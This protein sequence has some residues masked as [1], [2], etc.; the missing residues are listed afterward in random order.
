MVAGCGQ[1]R[2]GRVQLQCLTGLFAI[3]IATSRAAWERATRLGGRRDR[4]CKEQ[5]RKV[6]RAMQ[7]RRVA[8]PH[9]WYS[10]TNKVS[11][12]LPSS[13]SVDTWRI[14]LYIGG[15]GVTPLS[16]S[17]QVGECTRVDD[18]W[19]L[20]SRCVYGVGTGSTT[21][22]DP[23]CSIRT[24]EQFVDDLEWGGCFELVQGVGIE[25]RCSC[26]G[27]SASCSGSEGRGGAYV[28]RINMLNVGT[29]RNS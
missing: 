9:Y 11:Q 21:F 27:G 8:F 2:T 5:V 18:G 4:L 19:L 20:V 12:Y 14:S 3:S 24:D 22:L 6:Q 13:S 23:G 25:L 26:A 1:F 10:H 7:R 28:V 29:A 17:G 15:C 16:M